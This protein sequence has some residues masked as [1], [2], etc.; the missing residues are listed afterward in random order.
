MHGVQ[1]LLFDLGGVLIDVDFNRVLTHWQPVSR[2]SLPAMQAAF[3]ADIPYQQHERDELS[4]AGYFAH[5][6]ELLQL[7]ADDARLAQGWNAIFGDEITETRLLVQASRARFKCCAF[8]NTNALHQVAW[9][10]RYPEVLQSFEHVFVSHEIG[11]RKPE[12][13]AFDHV[14]RELG[15][16]PEEILFFDDLQENVDGALAAGLQAVLVRSP[17]DVR[18]A[19]VVPHPVPGV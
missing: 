14:A 6:R 7:Q 15:L 9:T 3:R 2:L 5:L 16:A 13:E 11:L 8:S 12:R 1:A 4:A 19:L 18:D 17:K 10:A